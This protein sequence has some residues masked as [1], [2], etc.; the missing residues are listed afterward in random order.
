MSIN[1]NEVIRYK[2]LIGRLLYKR[3]S[4]IKTSYHEEKLSTLLN[5]LTLDNLELKELENGLN[6]M[7]ELN[8]I[9]KYEIDIDKNLC[10]IYITDK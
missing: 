4:Y 8:H 10:K 2:N 7:M 5:E 9:H 3:F 1:F 6:E